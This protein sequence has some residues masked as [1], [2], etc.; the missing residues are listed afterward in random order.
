[1]TVALAK[2]L[3]LSP[4]E[5]LSVKRSD[6]ERFDVSALSC[7][8]ARASRDAIVL[9]EGLELLATEEWRALITWCRE[10]LRPDGVLVLDLASCDAT[11]A[12]SL[13][14]ALALSFGAVELFAWDGLRRTPACAVAGDLLAICQ[15]FVP[16]PTRSLELLRPRV[17]ASGAEWQ[18]SWLCDQPGLPERFLLRATV[19]AIGE[20][21]GGV[22]IRFRFLAPAGARFRIEGRLGDPSCGPVELLLSSQLAEARGE[23]HWG[24]VQRIA[25]DARTD[26]GE[27]LDIRVS[28]LRVACDLASPPPAASRTSADLR[29]GYDETY[30]QGMPG[31]KLYREE[32]EL[33]ERVSVHRAYAL[34][35]SPTPKRVVDVGSGRGELAKHLIE[36]GTE[37]TLLDYAPAA[38]ELART[39][40]GERPGLTSWS[41]TPPTWAR[42][43]LSTTRTRS[44]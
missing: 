38:M 6:L 40:L 44:S 4:S 35:L 3:A 27:V 2:A 14:A 20:H 19:E 13:Q 39:L 29:E 30:Y 28:D 7:R 22:D 33:S 41:T 23:P 31:Y 36:R 15:P 25:L 24:A 21:S 43:S 10:V 9:A 16:Y 42:T 18:S 5:P 12:R 26:T 34:L 8:A 17:V 32:R 37:V 11:R 1:M